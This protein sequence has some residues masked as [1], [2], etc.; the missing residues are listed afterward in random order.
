MKLLRPFCLALACFAAGSASAQSTWTLRN[1]DSNPPQQGYLWGIAEGNAGV[2][3]V[4][5]E[6][7]I[8]HS[9]DGRTWARRTSGT[10]NWLVAVTFGNGRYLAVGDNGTILTSTNAIVWTPV[11]STGT[12]A[13]LNN[14]LFAQNKFVAVGEGGAIVVSTDGTTWNPVTS[15]AG[16]A[17]LRG[18]AYGPGNWIATGQSGTITTSLDGITW[19]KRGGSAGQADFEAV[20]NTDSFSYVYSNYT[21]TY[22]YFLLAGSGGTVQVAY[23]Y[24]Y[25]Y[26]SNPNSN[27]QYFSLLTTS[28]PST[29]ARFRS[30]SK[31]NGAYI[32]TGENGE[33]HTARSQYGPWTKIPI[34]TTKN[35][36]GAGSALGSLVLIGENETIFQSEQI[37]LSKLGN[38]STRGAA[39]SGAGAMIAGTVVR[40]T[41]PKQFLVRGIGPALGA[42]GVTGFLADPVLSIFN[43]T[44]QL[45]T[46]NTGWGTNLNAAAIVT[47]A[48]DFGA[49]ALNANSRDSA[50][51][52]TLNP[53]TYT[54]QLTSASG[55]TGNALV[56]A[57]D[58]DVIDATSSRAINISTRGQVGTGENILIAGL[59]VQG[60]SARTLLIRGVGPTLAQFGVTGTLADPIIKVVDSSGAT[61]ATNDNWGDTSLTNGRAVT[62]DEVELAAGA[63]GAFA[64]ATGSKDAALIITLVPGSYTIQVSGANNTTGL[65]LVEA[66]DVPVE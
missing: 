50:L 26:P 64:L 55:A 23:A 8:L 20:T 39:T 40:G 18:L 29:T 13:R 17:W 7:R 19:T 11:S 49:F 37:F 66:Y 15:N 24:S 60:Q 36:V 62:A 30:V 14:V 9:V 10:T 46:S 42:F 32:V 53:G 21:L 34:A 54:F 28:R 43:G 48:R 25:T 4:G 22:T 16:T 35:L 45:V 59:V 65:A 3:T 5:T 61:I 58:L 33:I 2:V 51:L 44:G 27:A 1:Q 12:T 41:R 56:E 63:S 47:A 6:G 57:Y 31:A 38:I 52:V